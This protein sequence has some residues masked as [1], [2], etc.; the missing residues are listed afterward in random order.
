MKRVFVFVFLLTAAL[1][2]RQQEAHAVIWGELDDTD[3]YPFVGLL[4]TDIDI[5]SGVLIGPNKFLTAAHCVD[6]ANAGASFVLFGQDPFFGSFDAFGLVAGIA[7]HNDYVAAGNTLGLA[8]PPCRYRIT[9]KV[10]LCFL[11]FLSLWLRP[12]FN[13]LMGEFCK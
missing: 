5:C 10:A 2:L 13:P 1:V 6:G 9:L 8:L 3:R 7:I 4:V 11:P 12:P